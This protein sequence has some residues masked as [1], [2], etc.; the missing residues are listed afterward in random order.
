MIRYIKNR[1]I[2]PD[3][4]VKVYWNLH[5]NCYS[6]QQNGLV[7]CHA[8]KIELKYANFKVSEAGRQRVLKERKKNVHAFVTGY[9]YDGDEERRY[10]ISIVYN[11][12]KYDS[13]R[14]RYSDRV[15]VLTADFVSLQSENGKGSILADRDVESYV[16]FPQSA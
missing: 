16:T 3:K 6:V 8:D 15:A 12:Y 4:P 11:P 14:L 10:D 9:L 1:T 2:N 13:F 5:R 7:V